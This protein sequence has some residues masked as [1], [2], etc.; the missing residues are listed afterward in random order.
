MSTHMPGF[1][2]FLMIFAS[3]C[4]GK[5]ATSSIRVE[6]ETAT[7]LTHTNQ[8]LCQTCGGILGQGFF[9]LVEPR[10]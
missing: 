3:F 1:Q 9:S 10:V 4:I 8:D 7:F 6:L 5:L 2:L